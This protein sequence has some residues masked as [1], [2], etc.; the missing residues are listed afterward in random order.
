MTQR[1]QAL[2]RA[3][4]ELDRAPG[5]T[6]TALAQQLQLSELDVHIMMLSAQA[7]RLVYKTAVGEWAITE[8]GRH[9][10][11]RADRATR[12]RPGQGG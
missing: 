7:N 9:I 11:R 1:R 10:I 4:G 12:R 6:C 8:R 5:L 2:D 3:L